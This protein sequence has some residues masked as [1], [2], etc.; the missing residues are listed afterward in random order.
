[1][2]LHRCNAIRFGSF[3][4]RPGCQSP[5][6]LD[7]RISISY[8]QILQN[9][10]ELLA[11]QVKETDFDLI[12]GVPYTAIP[13]ATALALQLKKPMLMKRNER[14]SYGLKK[15]I[16]G[17]Y[18]PGSCCLIVEDLVCTGNSTYETVK[19]LTDRGL[20][21]KDVVVLV[22]R[23][24]GA[25]QRL[26]RDGLRLHA[27]LTLGQILDTLEE[28]KLISSTLTNEVRDYIQNNQI[29]PSL[30]V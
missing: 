16:E 5:I 23:E 12:C 7:L 9:I 6:Y 2:D 1:M 18:K 17:A 19:P 22:D 8:P 15:Q 25:R 4:L 28:E 10:T 29:T 11:D 27:V 24:Q 14:K 13:F 30:L 3:T 21:I 26:E 20:V